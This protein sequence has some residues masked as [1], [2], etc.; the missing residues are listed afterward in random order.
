MLFLNGEGGALQVRDVERDANGRIRRAYVVNGWWWL[1]LK[2][3]EAQA[4]DGAA[5]IVT[6]WPVTSYEE[7]EVQGVRG[8]YNDVIQ[9]AIKKRR[10]NAV[11]RPR[12]VFG[13]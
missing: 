4:K 11:S 8:D 6:R 9:T 5:H 1:V 13:A 2:N 3:G 7:V 10:K 12:N